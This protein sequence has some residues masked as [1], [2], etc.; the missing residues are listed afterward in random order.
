MLDIVWAWKG[1]AQGTTRT[2]SEME[3]GE[4]RV[5][6][7]WDRTRNDTNKERDG[8]WWTMCERGEGSKKEQ[9]RQRKILSMVDI[10]WALSGSAQRIIQAKKETGYGRVCVDVVWDRTESNTDKE[11]N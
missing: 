11:R 5:E 4:C 2:K 8:V 9:H 3:Y 7:E 1:T 6:V 10:V